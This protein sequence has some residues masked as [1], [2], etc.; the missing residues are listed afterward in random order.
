MRVMSDA[1][2]SSAEI[3][4]AA[5]VPDEGTCLRF[6]GIAASVA[7]RRDRYVSGLQ[8]TCE[9]VNAEPSRVLWKRIG[10]CKVFTHDATRAALAH[11]RGTITGCCQLQP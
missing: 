7:A 1:L 8:H 4:A 2:Q 9:I 10:D 6:D 11:Q 5:H 3:S